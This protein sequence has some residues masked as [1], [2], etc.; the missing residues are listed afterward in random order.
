MSVLGIVL[1]ALFLVGV[2]LGV[3]ALRAPRRTRTRLPAAA[4]PA[5][6]YAESGWS[7]GAGDEFDALPEAARANMVFAVAVLEDERSQRLLVHALAD[8]SETVALA[9]AHVL[10]S[11]GCSADVEQFLAANPGERAERIART[12]AVLDP[13]ARG[14]G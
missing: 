9:A 2:G 5:P 10:G 1:M 7:R 3:Y 8:P 11:R 13:Q 4:E 12:L 14:A 6:L